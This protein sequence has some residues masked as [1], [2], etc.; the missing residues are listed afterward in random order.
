MIKRIVL[1]LVLASS[2][3][4]AQDMSPVP[5]IYPAPKK[6]TFEH[7]LKSLERLVKPVGH[8]YQ[9]TGEWIL[10]I[11]MVSDRC[12]MNVNKTIMSLTLQSMRLRQADLVGPT[13]RQAQRKGSTMMSYYWTELY[14]I[15]PEK[16]CAVSYALW[17]PDGA[18]FPGILEQLE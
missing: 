5:Q 14:G 2:S 6:L 12:E 15:D 17:G 13:I 9:R 3:A 16:T 7:G 1:A 4:P 11:P 8:D 10:L 18:Q